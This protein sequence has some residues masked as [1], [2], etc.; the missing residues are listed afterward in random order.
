VFVREARPS[1]ALLDHTNLKQSGHSGSLPQRFF[2]LAAAFAV[3]AFAAWKVY[4]GALRGEFVYD[5]DSYVVQNQAIRSL[6]PS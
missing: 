6:V 1:G 5:D 4:G 3:L 2:L